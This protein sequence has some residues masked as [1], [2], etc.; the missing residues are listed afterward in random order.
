MIRRI[1]LSAACA[2]FAACWYGFS[3]G[4]LPKDMKTVAVLTFTNETAAPELQAEVVD[5]LREA[6]RKRLNLREAPE[7]KANARV[8]GTINRYEVDIPSGSSA[9]PNRL[10]ATHRMLRISLNIDVVDQRSGKTL[11]SGN[12]AETGDYAEGAE[13]L[14]RKKAID[15]II[16][17][18]INGMQ[19]Q[20]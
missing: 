10:N 5:A 12:V 19:S 18:I 13:E 6:L 7:A 3:G 4:G 8:R 15:K 1:A 16:D 20:W 14:G 2:L 9:D 17:R 11:F